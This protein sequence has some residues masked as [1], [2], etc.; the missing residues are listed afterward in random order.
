MIVLQV[1]ICLYYN[2]YVS[3]LPQL[4]QFKIRRTQH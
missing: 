2:H 1:Y 3:Q 4:L